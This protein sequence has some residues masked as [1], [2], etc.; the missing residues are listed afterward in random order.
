MSTHNRK[1]PGSTPEKAAFNWFPGHMAKALREIKGKLK[2]V[3]IVLEIRDARAPLASSNRAFNETLGEK[4]RLILLNKLN[5]ADPVIVKEWEAWFKEQ[6]E[7]YVFVNCFDKTSLKKVIS[8]ARKV[9]EDK[10]RACNPDILDQKTKLRLMIVGLPNTGK[11]TIINQLANKNATKVADKPGLTQM[12]QWIT[13]DKDLELLDT[14]GVMPPHIEKEEHGLW[15]SA[16]HA[17][18]DAIVGEE[19][20]A[21][22]LVKHFLKLE[23]K[24]F[25]ERYKL[26]SFDL[27]VDDIIMKIA[28]ARGCLK[29]KG[30]PDLARVYKIIL[31][32]FREG[33]LGKCCFGLPPKR[34]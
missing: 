1:E 21:L 34:S 11:S 19:L 32:D 31:A 23:S 8:M 14:P 27:S 12:Q 33:S 10:R 2:T 16:I 17:I 20:P 7:P 22:F 18:P 6:G 28:T 9:V 30:L 5:L 3:D 13:I 15:L 29:Q 25:K 4:S 24:E 26:E